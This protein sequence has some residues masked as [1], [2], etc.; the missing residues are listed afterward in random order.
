MVASDAPSIS[1]S[2]DERT[3]WWISRYSRIM[4]WRWAGIS[5]LGIAI[6]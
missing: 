4:R 1:E 3:I 6:L 5:V 2:I